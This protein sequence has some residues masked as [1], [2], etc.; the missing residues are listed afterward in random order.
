MLRPSDLETFDAEGFTLMRFYDGALAYPTQFMPQD[1]LTEGG[2][3][4]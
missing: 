3:A 1:L 4:S 2:D